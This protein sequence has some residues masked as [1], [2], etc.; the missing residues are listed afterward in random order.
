M[1]ETFGIPKYQYAEKTAR[2]TDGGKKTAHGHRACQTLP[3]HADLDSIAGHSC[4]GTRDPARR[5]QNQPQTPP[6]RRAK[7]CSVTQ[8]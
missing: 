8:N 1:A 7:L 2:P 4:F 6:Y 5:L 3:R